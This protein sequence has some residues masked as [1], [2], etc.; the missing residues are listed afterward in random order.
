M[1]FRLL[2]LNQR[3]KTHVRIVIEN[4]F[5]FR[6]VLL[7]APALWFLALKKYHAFV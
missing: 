3:L 6:H 2:F 7:E 4:I 5:V 1:M